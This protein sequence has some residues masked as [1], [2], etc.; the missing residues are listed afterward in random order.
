MATSTVSVRVDGH[1]VYN[2]MH[3]AKENTAFVDDAVFHIS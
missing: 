1:V 3:L 2:S